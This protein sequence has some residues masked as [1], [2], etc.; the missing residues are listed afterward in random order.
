ME[1]PQSKAPAVMEWWMQ[2]AALGMATSSKHQPPPQQP[3]QHLLPPQQPM[4]RYLLKSRRA[5]KH[6][7]QCHHQYMLH[8]QE[9]QCHQWRMLYPQYRYDHHT[10]Q[11]QQY[12]RRHRQRNQQWQNQHLQHHQRDLLATASSTSSQGVRK[13][14]AAARTR[15]GST[16]GTTNH[17]IHRIR[18]IQL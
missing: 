3:M 14:P 6:H 18:S 7:P 12:Q 13:N 16:D 8:L 4:Q 15:P 2:Q 17:R 9:Y 11:L 10:T 5:Q 1:K